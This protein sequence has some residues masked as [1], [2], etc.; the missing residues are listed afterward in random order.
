[1]YWMLKSTL[2]DGGAIGIDVLQFCCPRRL[3]PHE[4]PPDKLTTSETYASEVPLA[5]EAIETKK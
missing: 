1:M 2:E 5:V 4:P 3:I